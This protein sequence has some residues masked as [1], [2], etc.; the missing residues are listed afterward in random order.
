MSEEKFAPGTHPN[1][2]AN[3]RATGTTESA[4]KAWE[5]KRQKYGE[6][7]TEK[8]AAGRYVTRAGYIFIKRP[9]HP[10]AN[11]RGYVREHVFVMSESI[12]RPLRSGEIVHHV[13]G[14]KSDNRIE[15]LELMERG[16]HHSHHHK[17]VIKPASV[18][19]LMLANDAR[20]ASLKALR[21]YICDGCGAR[22]TARTRAKHA[23]TFC[24]KKCYGAALSAVA[25]QRVKAP[26]LP[27]QNT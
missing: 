9:D 20:S 15:N 25:K 8:P 10:N 21:T 2:R 19:A 13:N 22:Y 14:D 26:M 3:L 11:A 7:G 6:R 18:R 1:S 16:A 5:T 17:D 12:S 24:S 23:R 27:P 4:R